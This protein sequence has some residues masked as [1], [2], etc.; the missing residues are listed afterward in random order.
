MAKS[1]KGDGAKLKGLKQA[2]ANFDVDWDDATQ[3][4]IVT[5]SRGYSA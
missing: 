4:I 1:S 2:I 5:T 3:W